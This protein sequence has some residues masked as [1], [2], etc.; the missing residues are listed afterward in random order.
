MIFMLTGCLQANSLEKFNSFNSSVKCL[1]QPSSLVARK[2]SCLFF[3]G[4]AWRSPFQRFNHDTRWHDMR[5]SINSRLPNDTECNLNQ[6]FPTRLVW[7]RP[8][9][10]LKIRRPI[11]GPSLH[12]F[13]SV[14]QCKIMLL[15]KFF[16]TWSKT[17]SGTCK[18]HSN[19]RA[20]KY[21]GGESSLGRGSTPVE[22]TAWRHNC[23]NNTSTKKKKFT[24]FF[25][26]DFCP[27]T[28]SM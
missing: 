22:W 18:Q 23:T 15:E 12:T 28:T 27:E 4:I 14:R 21:W 10:P 7:I 11:N 5:W 20:W 13:S 9:T 17:V 24:P 1:F 6:N 26:E 3:A 2:M 8:L 19:S 25:C 16:L